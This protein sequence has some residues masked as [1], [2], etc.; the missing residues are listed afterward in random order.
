MYTRIMKKEE[1]ITLRDEAESVITKLYSQAQGLQNDLNNT[2][3][4]ADRVRGEY[5]AYDHL[6]KE[7]EKNESEENKGKR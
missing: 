4:E 6:I 5:R 7:M 3:I 2:N 1:L